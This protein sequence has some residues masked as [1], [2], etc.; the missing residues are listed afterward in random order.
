MSQHGMTHSSEFKAWSNMKQRCTNPKTINYKD[1]GG[2]GIKVCDRWFNSFDAFLEDMG[3]K[4]DSSLTLDRKDNNGDYEPDNC[5]WASRQIQTRN[6]REYKKDKLGCI[7]VTKDRGSWRARIIF[8]GKEIYLGNF[9]LLEDA[10]KARKEGEVKYN[11][12][13]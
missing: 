7:G 8:N 3:S 2:R 6:I 5:R 4:P 1:Y 9:K 12:G 11:V 13:V 10:I